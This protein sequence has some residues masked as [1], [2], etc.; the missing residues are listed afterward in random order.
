MAGRADH[1]E[2]YAAELLHGRPRQV[3]DITKNEGITVVINR[4]GGPIPL[5]PS[6]TLPALTDDSE[7]REPNT[8]AGV[9]NE[10]GPHEE[11]PEA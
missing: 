7:Y 11:G 8:K 6:N 5:L 9:S 1:M 2:K 4:G 3:L 10:S